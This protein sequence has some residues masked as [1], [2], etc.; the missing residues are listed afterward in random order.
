MISGTDPMSCDPLTAL[1]NEYGADWNV[2]RP[3]K[4]LADHRRL[5]MTLVSDSVAGLAEKL[6][7]FTCL[8]GDLP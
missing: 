5:D 3:G 4:Y 2:W 1:V 6:R 8:T 7:A